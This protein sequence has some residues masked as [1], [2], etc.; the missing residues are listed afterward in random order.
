MCVQ[1]IQEGKLKARLDGKD[2]MTA[3]IK[4]ACQ[5]S[6]PADAITFGDLNDPKSPVAKCLKDNPRRYRVLAELN[7]RPSV[8]YLMKVRNK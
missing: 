6:C 5:Q 8:N 4:T 2:V 1:R 7:V 3:D